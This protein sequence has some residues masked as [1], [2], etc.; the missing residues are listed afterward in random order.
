MHFNFPPYYPVLFTGMRD[1]SMHRGGAAW[2]AD[3]P[4]GAAWYSGQR[5]WSQPAQLRDFYAIGVDQPLYALVLTP[6]T[7]DRPFFTE[8]SRVGNNRGRLGEWAQVYSGL[9]TRRFPPGFSL[10]FPQKISDNLYV[11][12]DPQVLQ[13]AGK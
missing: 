6:H 1:D 8:L 3:V 10:V 4:A 2:M 12:F 9:L 7:L 5:V 13:R 11:L